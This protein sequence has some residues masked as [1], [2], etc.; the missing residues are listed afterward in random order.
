MRQILAIL[1]FLKS[2]ESGNHHVWSYYGLRVDRYPLFTRERDN[3]R[4]ALEWL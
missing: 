1:E 4:A 2:A 3:L